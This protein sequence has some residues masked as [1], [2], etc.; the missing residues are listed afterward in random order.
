MCPTAQYALLLVLQETRAAGTPL[1]EIEQILAQLSQANCHCGRISSYLL[2]DRYLSWL[3]EA[4]H[5]IGMG[6]SLMAHLCS[7]RLCIEQHPSA[8]HAQQ[9]T[10]CSAPCA[11]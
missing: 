1:G 11:L 2:G 8:G 6:L 4:M 7:S 10:P 3:R 5:E 9:L